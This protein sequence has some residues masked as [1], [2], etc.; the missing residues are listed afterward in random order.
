MEQK[1]W[2]VYINQQISALNSKYKM[3]VAQHW[4]DLLMKSI[5]G[6]ADFETSY[7]TF[8]S[9]FPINGDTLDKPKPIKLSNPEKLA[10]DYAL[11]SGDSIN[12]HYL[13]ED[14]R[15]YYYLYKVISKTGNAGEMR[16][17]KEKRYGCVYVE[18]EYL[19]GNLDSKRYEMNE[20]SDFQK[21][22]GLIV[23]TIYNF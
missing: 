9:N 21:F 16:I 17:L 18:F 2:E 22:M 14:D 3:E 12:I 15:A 11:L 4:Q 13:K 5:E 10:K 20:F 23:D 8:L 1:E 6:D 19:N 7:Q